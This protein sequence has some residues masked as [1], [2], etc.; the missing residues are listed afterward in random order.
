M[1]SLL[2]G[3]NFIFIMTRRILESYVED[4]ERKKVFSSRLDICFICFACW[5][6]VYAG[7]LKSFESSLLLLLF[8]FFS[9]IIFLTVSTYTWLGEANS[10]SKKDLVGGVGVLDV[11]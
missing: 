11:F 9:P 2:F 1:S 4:E 10:H 3:R 7:L 6:R 8:F 5:Q